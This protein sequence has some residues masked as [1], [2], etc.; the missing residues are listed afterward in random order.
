MFQ[1]SS[2]FL[3]TFHRSKN[4]SIPHW[5]PHHNEKGDPDPLVADSESV[6]GTR[7]ER[8]GIIFFSG[9]WGPVWDSPRELQ[10]LYLFPDPA[11]HVKYWSMSYQFLNFFAA[12]FGSW[13]PLFLVNS[14]TFERQIRELSDKSRTELV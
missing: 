6:H 11:Y 12:K 13:Y 14:M 2:L 4:V 3:Y 10:V 5:S 1:K 8:V 9:M 7:N